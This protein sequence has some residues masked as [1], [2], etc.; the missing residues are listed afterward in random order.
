MSEPNAAD[1]AAPPR[2]P[3]P[4]GPD[5]PPPGENPD[6]PLTPVED[7]ERVEPGPDIPPPGRGE[8]DILPGETPPELP[9][10]SLPPPVEVPPQF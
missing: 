5:I 6:S 3:E 7:P 10:D 1:L 4:G 2:T 8:P 9:P